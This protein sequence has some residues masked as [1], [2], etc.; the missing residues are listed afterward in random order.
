MTR[1]LKEVQLPIPK[2]M[3]E[4][5][6]DLP[7][8]RE[9][10]D[11]ISVRELLKEASTALDDVNNTVQSSVLAKMASQLVMR[12]SRKRGTPKLVVDLEGEASLYVSYAT[13]DHPTHV[14]GVNEK[15]PSLT[16]LRQKADS[17]GVDIS[18]LGRA[19]KEIIRRLEAH[20]R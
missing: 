16:E 8:I 6:L 9:G 7:V 14:N 11:V 19:K 5:I 13:D 10:S 4:A 20:A 17:L 15:L 12:E 2:E 3:Q 18:D 1:K